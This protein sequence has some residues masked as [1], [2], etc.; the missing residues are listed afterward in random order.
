MPPAASARNASRLQRTFH[1]PEAGI[2]RSPFEAAES[3]RLRQHT[4]ASVAD[5][6]A[7]TYQY[8]EPA[9]TSSDNLKVRVLRVAWVQAISLQNPKG[10][11]LRGEFYLILASV[12]AEWMICL[13]CAGHCAREANQ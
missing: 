2:G 11:V 7:S 12:N 10:H 9:P 13:P 1:R 4:P 8:S 3:S 5:S 6:R